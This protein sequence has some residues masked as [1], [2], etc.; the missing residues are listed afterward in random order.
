[1]APGQADAGEHQL[2]DDLRLSAEKRGK[3]CCVSTSYE[4]LWLPAEL[5]GHPPQDFTHGPDAA[6]E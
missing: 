4:E 2:G 3:F 5:F 6:P 1:M